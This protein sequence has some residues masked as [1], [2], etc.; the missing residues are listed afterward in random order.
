MSGNSWTGIGNVSREVYPECTDPHLEQLF[1][2]KYAI[3]YLRTFVFGNAHCQLHFLD[4]GTVLMLQVSSL[5]GTLSWW[6][7]GFE[8]SRC[9]TFASSHQSKPFAMV[10]SYKSPMWVIFAGLP[11]TFLTYP[12]SPLEVVML[13]VNSLSGKP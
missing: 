7:L 2:H 10:R 13:W 12:Q 11:T 3:S 8:R 9:E 1:Q 4:T 6:E 5:S